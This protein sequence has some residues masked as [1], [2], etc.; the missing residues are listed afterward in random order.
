MKKLK[1]LLLAVF[2]IFGI[3][4]LS[5]CT[6]T[7]EQA[8]NV[9]EK[10]QQVLITSIPPIADIAEHI[11]GE[12]FEIYSIVKENSSPEEYE[13]STKDLKKIAGAKAYLVNGTFAFEK[14]YLENIKTMNPD[15]DIVEISKNIILL[16]MDDD[17]KHHYTLNAF[18]VEPFWHLEVE[19]WKLYY[20][21]PEG[22]Q[23][24]LAISITQSWENLRVDWPTAKV[25]FT[26][27]KCV[28]ESKWDTHDYTVQVDFP[29]IQVFGCGDKITDEDTYEHKI[30]SFWT[31]WRIQSTASASKKIDSSAIASEWH[32]HGAFD[33]HYWVSKKNIQIIAQNIADYLTS[34]DRINEVYYTNNLKAFL[35]ELN[36]IREGQKVSS[37]WTEWRIQSTESK[38][39][40]SS[41]IASEWHRHQHLYIYHP[42]IR[43]FAEEMGLDVIAF[44]QHGK[45]TTSAMIEK[46]LEH[47]DT[48]YDVVLVDPQTPQIFIEYLTQQGITTQV[49][50]PIKK[51][52][53][54][55][56]SSL[57]ALVSQ[58]AHTQDHIQKHHEHDETAH[59][60]SE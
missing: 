38:E 18:W 30:S 28:D 23:D 20:T 59:H 56:L 10:E 39:I 44:Q 17:E 53:L 52:L 29:W 35:E 5:G 6:L 11:A 60:H 22:R 45:A 15:L 48:D 47:F 49:F 16:L 54:T 4:G 57:Y 26:A 14:Q 12:R 43:Y 32:S 37:F 42:S 9:K 40:D 33:P 13:I 7:Q 55:N 1:K 41:A 34:I 46:V 27:K 19:D 58:N 25:V 31:K 24:P 51:D 8:H 36:N 2:V 50:N 3:A 21:N